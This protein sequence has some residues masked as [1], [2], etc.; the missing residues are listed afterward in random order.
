MIKELEEKILVLD[1]ATGTAIQKY[2]LIDSSLNGCNE[3]LNFERPDIIKE[4]HKKYIEAGAD[5]IE[6]NS[7]NSNRISLGEYKLSD[8]AYELSKKSAMIAKEAVLEFYGECNNEIEKRKV[9]IAGSV[10]PTSKSLSVPTGN[11]PYE[12]GVN[13]DFLKLAYYEQ[14]LGLVDGGI[15]I[16]L[17]ETIF[18]GLNAKAALLAAEEVFKNKKKELPIMISM[19]VNKKGKLLSGQSMES[20]VVALERES[21]VSF[22]LNC[23]FGAKELIPIIKKLGEFTEKAILF[24]PNAGLPN[25]EGE[26]LETPE[27]TASQLKELVDE[28]YVN[29]IG[30]C[31]GTCFD[32]TKEISK[33]IKGK[34][35]RKIKKIIKNEFVLSGNEIYNFKSKFTVVG[36]RNNVAGSR[37]FKRLIE[38]KNYVKALEIARNQV[39][40]GATVLDINLDDGLL[41]SEKE[42]D[43]YLKIMQNDPIVSKFPIMIDSSDFK[44]IEIALKTTQGKSIVNSISLKEGEEKFIKKALIIKKYGAAVIAMAF[45]EKGQGVS[46]ERKIEIIEREFN[47]LK[48]IGFRDDNILFDPNI[49]T[50]GTGSESDQYNGVY[51]LEAVEWIRNN[52]EKVGIIGGLSNLSFAFRGNNLLRASIHKLFIDKAKEL[53]MNFAIMNPSEKAPK[54]KNKEKKA[55]NSLIVGEEKAV[56]KVLLISL[57]NS[58]KENGE[59]PHENLEE[60]IKQAL[61]YGGS[62]TFENDINEALKKYSPIEIIQNVLM[63]GMDNVGKLFE[64]GELYLPQIIRSAAVMNKAIDIL[65]PYLSKDE[66]IKE[67]GTVLMATVEGDVHD[68]GK[69]I[70]GTV[71]KCNGFNI[72]DLGVMVSKEKIYEKA[73][74]VNADIVTLSGL[75]S[76]SLKEME[77]IL[78]LFKQN[79]SNIPIFVAGATT[80][81]LH[82]ALK[83]EPIYEKKVVHVTDALDTL[84]SV[85]K[86]S[87]SKESR[88]KF[89]N[90][91]N[92]ELEKLKK[93]YIEN[94]SKNSTIK[95]I[96]VEYKNKIKRPKKIGKFYLEI[97]LEKIEDKINWNFILERLKVK[98]TKIEE[99]TLKE[100]KEILN[101]MKAEKI[102][103]KAVFGIFE[104]EK[105]LQNGEVKIMGTKKNKTIN[106]PRRSY[107]NLDIS[108]SD[109]LNEK[110]FIGSFVISITSK[111]FPKN[112][113]ENIIENLILMEVTEASSKYLQS[114][115]IENFWDVKIRPAIGYNSIPDHSLKKLVFDTIAGEKTGAKL[116]KNFSMYPVTS[117]CGFYFSSE[118]SFYF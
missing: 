108:L 69:N 53:G 73:E 30:G 111:M 16:V 84:I 80:S 112:S 23:S 26:Y 104:V 116:T 94:K 8:R 82:T 66:K 10:G 93:K 22:G 59:K 55:I 2:R 56:D 72:V 110:D 13:F 41:D 49:L 42:M 117:V 75:I 51:Y 68:I 24:Y 109:F 1:G 103:S 20:L 106:F 48:K 45:D 86:V 32:H 95:K 14:I 97:S 107:R 83:L 50:I 52:L 5:I 102:F 92:L 58:K 76:P 74:E 44:T 15:D 87:Q 98:N 34:E 114:Y 89:L 21:I 101:L 12:R 61:M 57:K 99:K 62:T 29:I 54:L 7:F 63:E 17:I 39:E 85:S 47:L 90:E 79:K 25:E 100:A 115:I 70:V 38:E 60:R 18:D 36:E 37:I 46:F 31:C 40:N 4:I 6:T 3:L 71:L 88:K 113:Y 9:Y 64:A 28:G 78:E 33:L 19:T 118:D 96:R 105:E 91:K 77:K 65:S 27:K 35:P 11:I 43:R 81:K 67:K